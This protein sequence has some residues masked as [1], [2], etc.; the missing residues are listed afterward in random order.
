MLYVLH[1]QK[2]AYKI[3]NI[4]MASWFNYLRQLFEDEMLNHYGL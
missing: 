4:L 3:D 1:I 2:K